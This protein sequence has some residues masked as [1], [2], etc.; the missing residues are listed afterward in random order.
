MKVDT[1]I[2]YCYV[3]LLD[4]LIALRQKPLNKSLYVENI[5]VNIGT[6]YQL[7]NY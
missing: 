6:N 7:T 1:S 2:I 4:M 5:R 3:A